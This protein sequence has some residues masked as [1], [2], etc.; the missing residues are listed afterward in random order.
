MR[1]KQER[2]ELLEGAGWGRRR[3]IEASTRK[4]RSRLQRKVDGG[5]EVE[6]RSRTRAQNLVGGEEVKKNLDLTLI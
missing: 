2:K 5:V 6:R 4:E 3:D 1:K